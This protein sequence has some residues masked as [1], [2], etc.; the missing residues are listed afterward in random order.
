MRRLHIV[1]LRKKIEDYDGDFEVKMVVRPIADDLNLEVCLTRQSQATEGSKT[2]N[3]RQ[4]HHPV[5]H[6]PLSR[7]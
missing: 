2:A 5:S 7:L 3:G 6:S 1:G 4:A